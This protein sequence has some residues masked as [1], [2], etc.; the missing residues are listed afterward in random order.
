MKSAQL[1]TDC[2]LVSGL[3][4]LGR[5]LVRNYGTDRLVQLDCGFYGCLVDS[6]CRNWAQISVSNRVIPPALGRLDCVALRSHDAG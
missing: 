3:N 4:I 6:A 2:F 5:C 1:Q